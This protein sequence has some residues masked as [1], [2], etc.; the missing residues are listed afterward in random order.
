MK[1]QHVYSVIT[2]VYSVMEIVIDNMGP[3]YD[4]QDWVD[5][6]ATSKREAVQIAVRDWLTENL[7][8]RDKNY[9]QDRKRDGL[10]PWTGIRAEIMRCPH[11]VECPIGFKDD[12]WCDQCQEEWDKECLAQ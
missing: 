12:F 1:E 5:V 3:T 6:V 10:C 9:V 8:Y 4:V 2:P 11:G 7:P